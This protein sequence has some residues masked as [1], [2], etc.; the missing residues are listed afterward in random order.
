MGPWI[1]ALAVAAAAILPLLSTLDAYFIAD[2]FG[3]IQLF[4]NKPPLHFLTLF[5]TPWTETIYGPPADELRPTV[6][7]SYQIDSLWGAGNP[8][9]YHLGSIA[10]HTANAL[11]VLAIARGLARLPWPAATFA[12]MVFALMPVQAEVG[13]WIS[14][15]ADSIPA[16]FYLGSLLAYGLWRRGEGKQP[17]PTAQIAETSRIGHAQRSALTPILFQRECEPFSLSP[18]HGGEAEGA[19][20]PRTPCLARPGEC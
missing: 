7:L 4:S 17:E 5:T 19:S 20:G 10:L 13:A 9:G 16:A 15:R 2:D 6:Q 8:F 18:A 12:G 1:A 3:L 11:L 14:G